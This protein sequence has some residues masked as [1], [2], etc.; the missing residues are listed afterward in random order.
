MRSVSSVQLAVDASSPTPLHRQLYGQLREAI[1]GRRI[2]PGARLPSTRMLAAE[3]G[4]S[5]NTILNAYEQ[6]FAEG[7]LDAR[8][9]SATRVAECLPCDVMCVRGRQEGELRLTGVTRRPSSRG[10]M[11]SAAHRTCCSEEG[12]PRPFRTGLPDVGEFPSRI[13]AGLVARYWRRPSRALSGYG[14]SAG[15]PPLRKAISDYLRESRGVCC[16]P[17]QVIVVAGS[18]QGLDLT[19]RVLLDPGDTVWMEDPGYLGARSAFAAA[20]ARLQPVPVDQEGLDITAAAETDQTARMAYVTPSHQYPLGA[21]MSLPRRL[22]LLDWAR[23][24][25]AWILEDDYDSEFRYTG[26]PLAALQGLDTEGC[27]VYLG[28]FSK[29]LSPALRLG[30]LVV[31]PALVDVFTAAREVAGEH[32]PMM[33]QAAL[34]DFIADGHFA[35]HIRRMRMIYAERQAALIKASSGFDGLF[36]VEPRPAGMHAT[37]WLGTGMDDQE[38]SRRAAEGGVDTRPM[39]IFWLR[40]PDRHGLLLGYAAFTPAEIREGVK[41]L[42]AALRGLGRSR[43]RSAVTSS[44]RPPSNSSPRRDL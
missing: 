41:K 39:S 25:G 33:E 34:A 43:R 3:I 11:F 20:G 15:Y 23:R 26:R 7:Y 16:E 37:L 21:L 36:E 17:G 2:R 13:W 42:S 19:A 12:P 6:L 32:A 24:T 22:R 28:T 29:V 10:A 44:R 27:V 31:P 9:G 40:P 8:G 5:R 18:Q 30:Y 14:F 38:T 4:V 35:R 1:L